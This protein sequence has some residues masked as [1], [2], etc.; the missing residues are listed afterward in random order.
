MDWSFLDTLIKNG[1][2]FNN[3]SITLDFSAMI[4]YSNPKDADTNAKRT[5]TIPDNVKDLTIVGPNKG[6]EYVVYNELSIK[7]DYRA[8]NNSL[9]IHLDSISFNADPNDGKG[10]CISA[11]YDALLVLDVLRRVNLTSYG[12]ASVIDCRNLKIEGNGEFICNGSGSVSSSTV[13]FPAIN[14]L[15]SVDIDMEGSLIVK[16]SEGLEDASNKEIAKG[17][18][19]IKSETVSIKTSSISHF[20]GGDG[21]QPK[22]PDKAVGRKITGANGIDGGD[23]GP[24]IEANI[25]TIF[26]SNIH[27]HAGNGGS[28][29]QGGQGSDGVSEWDTGVDGG[30]G[31][32]G[33]QGGMGGL[34][35]VGTLV[36][37]SSFKINLYGGNGG[38]GGQ[39]GT[40]GIGGISD[41]NGVL[42]VDNSRHKGLNGGQGGTGGVGGNS[43]KND[44]LQ[45][46]SDDYEINNIILL[47]PGSGGQG[48]EGG[49]KGYIYNHSWD[50]GTYYGNDGKKGS[51][52]Q[53][54]AY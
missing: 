51:D 45:F 15:Y 8:A 33:G 52:G 37:Q 18:A 49:S 41:G 30:T 9:T 27:L 47:T 7:V 42:I 6:S 21:A 39:G 3:E 5:I 1:T 40:G 38:Q 44:L 16:G 20:Y 26:S 28:G 29:G 31:G 54:G 2:L 11:P 22:T 4:D 24:A 48:G 12:G 53:T 23:G 32:N 50:H 36:N 34:P 25:I 10:V 43:S 35:F 17:Q 19:A 13:T 14:V 46:E